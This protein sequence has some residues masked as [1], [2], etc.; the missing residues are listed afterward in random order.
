MSIGQHL[1]SSLLTVLNNGAKNICTQFG[2]GMLLFLW[3]EISRS[4]IAESSA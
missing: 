1:V 4:G 3:G 2:E